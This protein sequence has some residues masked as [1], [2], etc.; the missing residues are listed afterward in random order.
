MTT[1]NHP[2]D[3]NSIFAAES[4]AIGISQLQ[5]AAPF[6]KE[7]MQLHATASMKI[8][9]HTHTNAYQNGLGCCQFVITNSAPAGN[10]R[11]LGASQLYQP[12]N[13]GYLPLK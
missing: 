4:N 11:R 6:A 7:V 9:A 5:L 1:I 2:L 12:P 8:E 10:R 3:G 13:I